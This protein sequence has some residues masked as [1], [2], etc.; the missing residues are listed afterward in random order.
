MTIARRALLA[1]ACALPLAATFAAARRVAGPA[2][3]HDL[4]GVWTNAWYTKMERPKAFKGLT[5]TAAEA[6]AFE[7]PR[8]AHHGELLDPVH[9]ELGQNESEFPDNGPGLARIRGE[10]R[11]SWI[12]DP[13]DGRIPWTP[14]AA[15]RL[16]IHVEGPEVLDNVENRDTDERCLTNSTATAPLVNAHDANLIQIVQTPGAVVL[17][18]EKNHE[19]RIIRLDGGA[20]PVIRGWTATSVGRWEGPTL[21]V[22]TSG[23]RAGVTKLDD[24]IYLSDQS[25]VVERFTRTGPKEIAYLFE[26]SDPS[27]FTRAWRGEMV[28]R[29]AEGMIYEYACHEGNYSLPTILHAAR[30]AEKK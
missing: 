25:R 27:L 18:G 9:D 12:T 11:T 6:E 2:N 17:V 10:Y 4:T 28:L 13:P 22:E 5:A 26:V 16:Y 14:E 24:N 3:P 19:A 7:A 8:R 1:A 20:A 15:K 21:V 23:L 30:M 29:Q